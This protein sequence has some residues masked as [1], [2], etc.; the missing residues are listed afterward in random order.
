MQEHGAGEITLRVAFPDAERVELAE[1][2]VP[3]MR[4]DGTYL[5]E[6]RGRQGELP[7]LY[8]LR[9]QTADGSWHE[10]YDPYAFGP[11][12]VAAD[13]E[14][15]SNG[16]THRAFDFLGAHALELEG[17][18]GVRFAVW[19]P[20]AER[21]SVVGH[22]NGWDG[23]AH[24]MTVRG[25]SG[26]WELFVPGLGAG[27]LYR[28]EIRNRDSGELRIKSDPYATLLEHRPATASIT[29]GDSRF[30]WRDAQ[31][32]RVRADCSWHREPIS[33]YEV[34]LGSWRRGPSGEF[35][36]YRELASSLA[37]HVRALGFTHVELMPITEHPLDD[38]WGYQCTGYFAPTR[39]HGEP[40]DLRAF[41][42]ELHEAGIGVMLDWVPGHFPRDDH[43]LA[44][45]D[46]T[47]LYEYGEPLKGEHPDWGTLVFNYSRNEVLSFLLSSAMYWLERVPFRRSAGRCRRFD[48]LSRLLARGGSMDAERARRQRESRGDRVPKGS[49]SSPMGLSRARI[50]LAEES[51]AWPQVSRPTY[52]GGL[53][54]S[55]KWNMGWMHD[56]LLYMRRTP[57][58][59][60]YHHNLLTFG[61]IYAFTEN[62]LLPLSHDEV[63]HGKRSLLD[64]DARRRLAAVRESAPAVLLPMD[65]SRA[66]SSCSWAASSA[67]PAN[68]TTTSRC[69]GIWPT[70]PPRAG[71][72]ALVRDLNRLYRERPRC[73]RTITSRRASPGSTGRTTRTPC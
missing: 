60:S 16:D 61:P 66:R 41:V 1:P 53:G 26:V 67:S 48:A 11:T 4:L 51:T 15:F 10:R 28:Y 31:W 25:S 59:G 64:E 36:G 50:T 73:T 29:P 40:D 30:A 24:P 44:R 71:L 12:L 54:F 69:P 52:Q 68:G 65:L 72:M 23:R 19:A 3:L 32:M 6:W 27:E 37:E 7:R 35:L 8:R 5:F 43:A 22:F 42:C 45:F 58:T 20:N 14:R 39:R 49:T 70:E 38:S 62:F 21:V 17:V 55:F 57:C 46:G 13:L 34:H 63:V 47:H 9:W 33:I 18:N 2:R 56:T